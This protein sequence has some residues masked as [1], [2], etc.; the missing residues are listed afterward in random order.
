VAR[1]AAL[2]SAC[3]GALVA[4]GLC[5]VLGGLRAA[6]EV[7]GLPCSLDALEELEAARGIEPVKLV[8][9][10]S[11]MPSGLESRRPPAHVPAAASA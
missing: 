2:E 5:E 7:V 10:H 6:D 11:V 4:R 9:A 8:D 3:A 1:A